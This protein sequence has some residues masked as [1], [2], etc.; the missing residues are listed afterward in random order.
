MLFIR[1][2][3]LL[4]FINFSLLYAEGTIQSYKV[5]LT[6]SYKTVSEGNSGTKTVS[7]DV[8]IDKCPSF[9]NIVI[10][11]ATKDGTAKNGSDYQKK[12]GSITFNSGSCNKTQTITL[13]INGDTD[14]ENDER[15]YLNIN[16][17][18]ST[19]QNVSFSNDHSTIKIKNDDEEVVN[20]VDLSIAKWS[21]KKRPAKNEEFEYGIEISYNDSYKGDTKAKIVDNVPS[22]LELL[23]VNDEDNSFNCNI[24]GNKVTCITK[25]NIEDYNGNP[26]IYI[27][28]KPKV[29]N[30]TI[31]NTASVT[32][33]NSA[34]SEIDPDDN[35]DSADIDTIAEG[36]RDD[37]FIT[38]DIVNKKSSYNVG[39]KV[40]FKVKV[41]NAGYKKQIEMKDKF[42]IGKDEWETTGSAFKLISY[43]KPSDVK[44]EKLK[45]N[46]N[47]YLDCY[48]KNKYN[49][50]DSFTVY[51]TAKI[52]KRG[53]LC[54]TAHGYERNEGW[55]S[56]DDACLDAQGNGAPILLK[57]I[58]NQEK[59]VGQ[60]IKKVKLNK[61][62][63]DPEGKKLTYKVTGLPKNT[64]YNSKKKTIK[65]AVN[66]VGTFTVTVTATD[67]EGASTTTTF[68]IKVKPRAL[69]AK[70]DKYNIS[71]NTKLIA[72][73]FDNDYGDEIRL[74][75]NTNPS[76]GTL[77]IKSSGDIKYI[78]NY[79]YTGED[80][81]KYTITDKSGKKSS[82]WAKITI[83]TTYHASFSDFKILNP[84][85]TRNI[86]GNYAIVGNTLSCVTDKTDSYSGQCQDNTSYNNNNYMVKYID[87]D[88][89]NLTWNSSSANINLPDSFASDNNKSIAWAGL[90]WQG[91]VNNYAQ[92]TKQRRAKI[93][94]GKVVY[95][96]VT[97]S[98]EDIDF[99]TIGADKV[100]I[101][102][103][104]NPNYTTISAS[105]FYYDKLFGSKGGFY[106]GYADVTSFLNSAKLKKGKN[107]ITVANVLANEGMEK[108]VGNYA[109]WSLVVIYKEDGFSA[110]PKNITVFGGYVA[111]GEGNKHAQFRVEGFRL[112]KIGQNIN[113]NFSLFSGEG[114]YL[115]GG[116][117]DKN[118]IDLIALKENNSSKSKLMPGLLKK[119]QNNIFDA[120]MSN[121]DRDSSANNNLQNNNNGIDVDTY[122]V[123]TIMTNFRDNNE[124][125]NSVILEMKTDGAAEG[126]DQTDYFTPS[127]IAFSTDL[128]APKLCYDYTIKMGDKYSIDAKDR[129]FTVSK[130]G[131]D[132][133]QIKVMIRS[134][135][136]DFNIENAKMYLTFSKNDVF[137]FN[138]DKAK[139]SLPNTFE[140]KDAIVIDE[141]KGS[142][143]IGS[144]P[145]DNGGVIK[146]KDRIYTK[147]YFNFLKNS[148]SGKF[149]IVLEGD[150]KFDGKN[151]VHY[152]FSS[153][154]P[155]KSTAYIER[156]PVNPT[157]NP[158]YGNFN[159]ERG[160]SNTNYNDTKDKKYSLFTQVTGVPYEVSVVSYK[161]ENGNYDT[162]SPID[163]TVELELIDA[164]NFENNNS[165]GYDSTC[166]DPDSVA[167]KGVFVSMGNKSRKK[168]TIPN[169]YPGYP[170]DTALKNATF[171]VWILTKKVGSE[172][173]IVNYNCKSSDNNNTCF[174]DL[175]NKEYKAIESNSTKYCEARCQGS[176]ASNSK[177][178]QCL[179]DNY[180]YPICARDNFAI[181][182]DSY[183][184]KISDSNETKTSNRVKIV[185]NN[186][187]TNI[188]QLAAGYKYD[189]D[190]N[191]TIFNSTQNAKWYKFVS[192]DNES[193]A[194]S[195]M[196][197]NQYCVDTNNTKLDL[198]IEN[199]TTRH[200][201]KDNNGSFTNTLSLNNVG[202]YEINIVDNRWT[203][204][205]HAGS[206]YKPFKS[207]SDCQVNESSAKNGE[208]NAK[209]GC[210]IKSGIYSKLPNIM[211][212]SH[213][214]KFDIS[215]INTLANPNSL[216][217]YVYVNSLDSNPNLIP[218]NIMALNITGSIV[219]KG[220][221]GKVLTNYIDGCMADD[222]NINYLYSTD[223][224]SL[225]T[226]KYDNNLTLQHTLFVTGIDSTPTINET[227][228]KNISINFSSKYFNTP[229][230]ANFNMYLNYKRD[231]NDPVSAFNFNSKDFYIKSPN[232][233]LTVNLN[234]NFIPKGKRDLN[235]TTRFYYA[236]ALPKVGFGGTYYDIYDDSIK[237]PVAIALYCDT[238]CALYGIN[239][240]SDLTHENNW[241][242]SRGHNGSNE[243]KVLVDVDSNNQ[244]KFSVTNPIESFTD[245]IDKSVNVSKVSGATI[246][247]PATVLITPTQNM[248]DN[249]SYLLYNKNGNNSAPTYLWK[250]KFVNS[251][252]AWSGE[253]K[254]GFVTDTNDTGRKNKKVEW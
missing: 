31:T 147:E 124:K 243:G 156:C 160:D 227:Q 221:D 84:E 250:N 209:R 180:G 230:I 20:D 119:E 126:A 146:A 103:G 38:K 236:A 171:R 246:T 100:L 90:F 63:K 201:K 134:Q 231:F 94:N 57:K 137:E 72:N 121:I 166:E 45:D 30:K 62:F 194:K 162:E 188:A 10:D 26:V 200:I 75:S 153:D 19:M 11:Y 129:N 175:Y 213:P 144:N 14:V 149:N 157:Y 181:R 120:K 226:A 82:A 71:I 110:K 220:K 46:G 193:I 163:T 122:D 54:N 32:H 2:I 139:V 235:T 17:N 85:D 207:L 125:M 47:P 192:E 104:D 190:V 199:G 174:M 150:I 61:Y 65:G 197:N 89:S 237:T 128:Y 86:L 141:N 234:Q 247:Y 136:A 59:F 91:A 74:V 164:S 167:G 40:K 116:K 138:K 52:L 77:E 203:E 41:T 105:D 81:F 155:P 49:D 67:P 168:L 244:G 80:K 253:G 18:E 92:N 35:K 9:N 210:V 53:H 216:S 225:K 148:F 239:T 28:V 33:L 215:A 109:G 58:P 178:Y 195:L 79:N 115:Y 152:I 228:D 208:L 154:A 44:C 245:G 69:K 99:N 196:V 27:K 23:R 29:A 112:P 165:D 113:S 242:Y 179:K 36:L 232:D 111:M 118:N 76:H 224:S 212:T 73:L 34:Y 55:L 7:F 254:T 64:I 206:I 219:A 172:H 87:I 101:K 21:S 159:V 25:K 140:Y 252:N 117:L 251:P 198:T 142:F 191:A 106:A 107:R 13:K 39:D 186:N 78:P 102:V 130:F 238:N 161:K 177:C 96:D 204:V 131:D 127:M 169:D 183:Y 1:N 184:M 173:K 249:Y 170:I 132:D 143:A 108:H 214:Y 189:I 37:V 222:T 248:K 42:P 240:N 3:I 158:I 135:E 83:S 93:E 211:I 22:D 66:E 16:K 182:P 60:Y 145:T 202:R 43:T 95:E 98:S 205:D 133:L 8:T 241:W 114:D 15:F 51:I 217:N 50:K 5:N 4:F 151:P 187:N 70:T 176:N 185:D 123:S 24:N 48:S 88:N 233:K 12:S 56:S 229:G 97:P 223:P 6:P 218:N 68:T